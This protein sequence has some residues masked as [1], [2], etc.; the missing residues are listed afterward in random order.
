MKSDPIYPFGHG[1]SYTD[2]RYSNL[3]IE[4]NSAYD[5]VK[6]DIS[7]DV[8]NT[9]DCLGKEVCQLYV[10]DMIGSVVRPMQELKDFS[11]VELKPGQTRTIRFSLDADKLACTGL[12]MQKKV[13]P[14]EFSIKIGSSSQDGLEG[15]FEIK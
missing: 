4:N 2:F 8:K 13:E 1:L 14:G 11:K 6:I 3:K 10:R 7:V 9:G 15:T 12:D 5:E